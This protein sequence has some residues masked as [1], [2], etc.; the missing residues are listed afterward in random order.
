MKDKT[1]QDYKKMKESTGE[2]TTNSVSEDMA[3]PDHDTN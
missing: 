2:E 3:T 1:G